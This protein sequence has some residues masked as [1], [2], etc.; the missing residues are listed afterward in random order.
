VA[1]ANIYM[2]LFVSCIVDT[3]K[4]HVY[5]QFRF[6]FV[7][8]VTEGFEFNRFLTF[9]YTAKIVKQL[10]LYDYLNH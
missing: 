8:T 6:H 1:L 5:V 9:T 4:V 7:L 2:G 10:H 3:Y